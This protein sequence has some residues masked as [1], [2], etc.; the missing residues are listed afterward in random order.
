MTVRKNK[1]AL[2]FQMSILLGSGV[3][4]GLTNCQKAATKEAAPPVI[5]EISEVQV[6]D[7]P[8]YSEW[9]ASLG[10]ALILPK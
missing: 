10:R 5:V 9:T 2:F 3:L 7:V 1:L 4:L 6:Q 8:I